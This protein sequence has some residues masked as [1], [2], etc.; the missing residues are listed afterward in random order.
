[1]HSNAKLFF[2]ELE[3]EL[4]PYKFLS[5]IPVRYED[6]PFFEDEWV[7]F[8]GMPKDDEDAKKIWSK[9]LSGYGNIT[10]GLVIWG[11]DAEE[12]EKDKYDAASNLRLIKDPKFFES[13]LRDWVRDST[14]PPVMGV[15]Y[16]SYADS[17][18]QGFVVCYIPESKHKPHRAEKANKQ[19][20]YRAGDDFLPA[21]PGLLRVLFY[22]QIQPYLWLEVRFDYQPQNTQALLWFEKNGDGKAF[23]DL[24]D[25]HSKLRWRVKLH[26]TGTSTA[27]DV[28]I[29]VNKNLLAS[30]DFG[31]WTD[32]QERS[33]Y[34]GE[35][36]FAASRPLHPGGSSA[37]F[38]CEVSEPISH[39]SYQIGDYLTFIPNFDE[40]EMTFIIYADNSQPSK[41]SLN[42]RSRDF[43]P[44]TRSI[45]K[46]VKPMI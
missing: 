38:S 7:D 29:V 27:R 14:N 13:K 36:A 8:K 2:D 35:I 25:S 3:K 40:T 45:T 4:D 1:M 20:Y 30:G 9:A 5:D 39:T 43:D 41:L 33:N 44:K 23:Q 24:L 18:G 28:Y 6:N 19:Y 21:E 11:I 15:E 37:S 17:D 32:W 31:Y 10:D 26:N 34:S 42:L 16:K 12:K 46:E 22:P